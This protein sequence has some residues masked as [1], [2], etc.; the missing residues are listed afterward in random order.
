M[1]HMP[2]AQHLLS[3]YVERNGRWCASLATAQH[4]KAMSPKRSTWPAS[5]R[6]LSFSSLTATAERSGAARQ[7]LPQTLAQ[8]AIAAGIA[9]E[10]VDGNDVI[11]VRFV[12]ERALERARTGG[13]PAVI[14][15]VTYRLSDHTT[16]DDASRYRDD[17]EVSAHWAEEPIARLRSHLVQRGMWNKEREEA[18]L[19]ECHEQ[20]GE[21][22]ASYLAT[23]PLSAAAMFDHVYAAIPAELAEQREAAVAAAGGKP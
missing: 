4:Q 22:A 20:V 16:A 23:P 14:E 12:V 5:G 18:L 2:S 10:Q 1:R 7:A 15:A 3:G 6:R 21:A 13:G 9:C 8:K 17:A 11:A 19:Q